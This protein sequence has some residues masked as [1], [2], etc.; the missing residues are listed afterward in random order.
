MGDY[1]WYYGSGISTTQPVGT[2]TANELGLYDMTGNVWEW[3]WDWYDTYPSGAQS[4]YLGATSSTSRVV[5][6]CS[7]NGS[8][9]NVYAL[10]FRTSHSP[11]NGPTDFGFRVAR[12]SG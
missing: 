11:G 4:D 2:K 1:A 10:T 9:D 12:I 3:C 8:T 7:F 5:R 6:S